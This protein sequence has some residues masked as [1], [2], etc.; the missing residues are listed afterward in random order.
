MPPRSLRK[1]PQ[2]P[3]KAGPAEPKNPKPPE[4]IELMPAEL[5]GFAAL[6]QQEIALQQ[7]I[8][9]CA[10]NVLRSRGVPETA[11]YEG[12][13]DKGGAY[14]AFTLKKES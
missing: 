7:R 3:P 11:I 8:A 5:E 14:V 2:M 12:E 6:R 4:R 10:A 9:F 1:L 13:K